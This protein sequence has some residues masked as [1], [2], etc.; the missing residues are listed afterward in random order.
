MP[1]TVVHIT[2]DNSD[3]WEAQTE[4]WFEASLGYKAKNTLKI[5]RIK[6]IANF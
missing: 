5:Y 6:D 4:E 2:Q 3:T 1:G